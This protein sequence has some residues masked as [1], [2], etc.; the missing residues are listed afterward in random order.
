MGLNPD[1][2]HYRSDGDVHAKVD[3]PEFPVHY[4]WSPE[5]RPHTHCP[6]C[7]TEEVIVIGGVARCPKCESH[8]EVVVCTPIVCASS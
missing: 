5:F 3:V 4:L 6:K 8:P 1:R 7:G 2:G